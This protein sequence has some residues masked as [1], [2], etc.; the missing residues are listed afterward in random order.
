MHVSTGALHPL[1]SPLGWMNP[2]SFDR[3][4]PFLIVGG[5][6]VGMIVVRVLDARA[7]RR[8]LAPAAGR[9][10]QS[11]PTVGIEELERRAGLALVASDDRVT[12]AAAEVDYAGALDG[13]EVAAVL[14]SAHEKAREQLAEAFAL[15]REAG[16][17]TAPDSERRAA[18]ERILRLTDAVDAAL[19]RDRRSLEQLRALGARAVEEHDALVGELAAVERDAAGS[20]A[21]LADAAGRYAAEALDPAVTAADDARTALAEVRAKLSAPAE[22]ATGTAAAVQL[23]SARAELRTAADRLAAAEAHLAALAASDLA[24]A[25]AIAALERDIEVARAMDSTRLRTVADDFAV[26]AEAL[27]EALA[28][29]GRDPVSLGRRV[30]RADAAIDAEIRAGASAGALSQRVLAERSSALAAAR[31]LVGTAEH[32]LSADPVDAAARIRRDEAAALLAEA[33]DLLSAAARPELAPGDAREQADAAAHLA[34]R[35]LAIARDDAAGTPA[36]GGRLFDR[37]A[38]GDGFFADLVAGLLERAEERD[39]A[40]RH[41]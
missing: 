6:V 14:R 16:L 40:A 25:D 26:E 35:S 31:M 38:G 22:A 19:D 9:A 2:W 17:T 41:D 20:T 8:E 23:T 7:K 15:Q 11:P 10:S 18:Y 4:L 36:S 34:R 27:R 3:L 32:A 39:A 13:D 12:A 5:L 21:R 30:V 29:A 1:A 37:A 24:V 33:R 28:A